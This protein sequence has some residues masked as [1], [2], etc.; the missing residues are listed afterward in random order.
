[1]TGPWRVDPEHPRDT[2]P[3]DTYDVIDDD[4][5]PV[6]WPLASLTFAAAAAVVEAHRNSQ[7]V[8]TTKEICA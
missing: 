5:L 8:T 3:A 1:M 6:A 2:R 4:G 7:C